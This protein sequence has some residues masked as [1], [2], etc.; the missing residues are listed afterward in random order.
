MIDRLHEAG[1]PIGYFHG[2]SKPRYDSHFN[3]LIAEIWFKGADRIKERSILIEPDELLRSQLVNRKTKWNS[4]GQCCLESKEE[5]KHRGV[6]SPDRADALLG[7]I[8]PGIV[9]TP[10]NL[11][12]GPRANYESVDLPD[13]GWEGDDQVDLGYFVPGTFTS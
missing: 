6:R 3:N 5:M 13:S 12:D 11:V 10:Y 4:A 7:A 1:W 8:S 9:Y 2:G